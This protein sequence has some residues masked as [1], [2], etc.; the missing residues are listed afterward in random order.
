MPTGGMEDGNPLAVDAVFDARRLREESLR[1]RQGLGPVVD[2]LQA[3]RA[4]TRWIIRS[5]RTTLVP[6]VKPVDA[7]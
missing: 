2:K 7:A 3:Q 4:A 1:L 6:D 5:I